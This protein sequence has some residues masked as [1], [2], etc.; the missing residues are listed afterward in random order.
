MSTDQSNHTLK[1]LG[2]DEYYDFVLPDDIECL[3]QLN[4]ENSI[5]DTARLKIIRTHF[6]GRDINM[7]PFKD[8]NVK[9]FRLQ[10]LGWDETGRR[11]TFVM[12]CLHC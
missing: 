5:S 12:G 4:R 8:M 2:W 10:L 11:A 7:Q 9:V 1:K 3:L 6:S